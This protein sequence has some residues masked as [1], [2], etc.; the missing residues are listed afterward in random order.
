MSH[1]LGSIMTCAHEDSR[2]LARLCERRRRRNAFSLRRISQLTEERVR[3]VSELAREH[4]VRRTCQAVQDTI[5]TR[6]KHLLQKVQLTLRAYWDCPPCHCAR[7]DCPQQHASAHQ[8]PHRDCP[9]RIG[10]VPTNK[11]TVPSHMQAHISDRIGT[12]PMRT[13]GGA[14]PRIRK[15]GIANVAS[16]L[17]FDLI[18]ASAERCQCFSLALKGSNCP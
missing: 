18:A 6:Q 7:G 5:V 12:V 9:D 10:T 16:F 15:I 2:W 13:S 4:C 14:V 3:D 8:R 17:L 11:G 1:A